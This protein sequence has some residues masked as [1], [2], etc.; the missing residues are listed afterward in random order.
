MKNVIQL[1]QGDVHVVKTSTGD[2]KD[3]LQLVKRGVGI[4]NTGINRVGKSIGF[5]QSDVGCV[6]DGLGTAVDEVFTL[7]A[8]IKDDAQARQSKELLDRICSTDYADEHFDHL[9]RHES[10]T[11]EWF[12]KHPKF[13]AWQN[14][15][16]VED[17]TLLCPGDPGTGKT[18]LAALSVKHLRTTLNA[19]MAPVLHIYCDYKRQEQQTGLHMI[20]SLLRQLLAFEQTIPEQIKSLYRETSW[21]TFHAVQNM[22]R[23]AMH[24]YTKLFIVLDALD[25]CGDEARKKLLMS[26]SGLR[27]SDCVHILATT[28]HA[29]PGVDSFFVNNTRLEIAASK[30]DIERYV[31]VRLSDFSESVQDN[32]E[33]QNQIVTAVLQA[34]DGM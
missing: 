9:Q 18:M 1:L 11:G 3:E 22:L 26:L 15:T 29:V 19:P 21:P 10:G 24:N 14:A 2:V 13:T 25:E 28:R 17:R 34:T 12:L 23:L 7:K 5:L 33:L 30:D 16:A 4:A 32:P 27:E 20:S 8:S 31:R 6:K